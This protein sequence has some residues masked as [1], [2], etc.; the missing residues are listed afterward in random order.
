MEKIVEERLTGLGGTDIAA[1]VGLNPFKRPIDVYV[2]KLQLAEPEEANLSMR[3]GTELE[4]FLSRE[5]MTR[6]PGVSSVWRPDLIRN[7]DLPWMIGHPDFYVI[8]KDSDLGLNTAEYG[9]EIKTT[10]SRNARL[11]GPE[12]TDEIPEWVLIQVEWYMG[13]DDLP[14]YDVAALIDRE[15]RIYRVER[16]NKLI[17]NLIEAGDHFWNNH[18]QKKEPPKVDHSKSWSEYLK[19]TFPQD[20]GET[21][22]VKDGSAAFFVMRELRAFKDLLEI[23]DNNFEAAKHSLQRLMGEASRLESP[24]GHIT[25]KRT[26][27]GKSKP[28]WE[29]IARHFIK[30][31][32]HG[33][34]VEK[35]LKME[36]PDAII[37][38]RKGSRRFLTEF[39]EAK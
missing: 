32:T 30:A 36:F 29:K 15:Q 20:T 11:W 14:Y 35:Y 4:T 8:S 27:D 7:K 13:I 34:S 6:F 5:Y 33:L 21:I 25:W 26:K 2:E 37:P 18:I 23:A 31:A 17:G 22:T 12:Y 3:L 24:I 1:I 28:D 9:L 38:G 39:K 10:G 19:A 16:D